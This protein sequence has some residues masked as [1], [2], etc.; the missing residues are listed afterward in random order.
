MA[1]A[2]AQA[3]PCA[4]ALAPAVAAAA[5]DVEEDEEE[6]CYEFDPFLF[7]KRLPPLA[8]CVPTRT[9]FLL[10]RQTRRSKNRTLVLDLD[11][12]LVHSTLEPGGMPAGGGGGSGV[13]RPACRADFHF[14]VEVGGTRHLVSVRLR[15]HLQ[16]FLER[17]AALFEVRG[18]AA[19]P[20]RP[21][22]RPWNLAF[23]AGRPGI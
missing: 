1:T 22:G 3:S 8:A 2:S 15:P 7:I 21:R 11:E 9:T 10:P 19:A 4:L 6:E 16:P 23:P 5:A 17:C 14:P 12:T 18:G 20:R 13:P